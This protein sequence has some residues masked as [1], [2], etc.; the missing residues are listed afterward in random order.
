MFWE[1]VEGK[2]VNVIWKNIKSLINC[3]SISQRDSRPQAGQLSLIYQVRIGQARRE[4]IR[5]EERCAQHSHFEESKNK[6]K[7]AD[8]MV[9]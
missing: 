2:R 8:E 7:F 9:I 1:L 5:W 3:L 4:L 6:M